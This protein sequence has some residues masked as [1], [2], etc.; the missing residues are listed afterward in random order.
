MNRI[1]IFISSLVIALSSCSSIADLDDRLTRLEARVKAIENILPTLNNNIEAL[2]NISNKNSIVSVESANG[3]YKLTLA[4][5]EVINLTQGS[6][7]AS[8]A[9]LVSIDKEGYWMVDYQDGNG[10][11]YILCD[12]KKVKAIGEDGL[13][14][15]FGVDNE[16]YW[17]VSYN[18]KDWETVKDVNG[19]PVSAIPSE[20]A[21]EY[22]EEVKVED[23]KLIVILKSGER[24]SIPIVPDFMFVINGTADLQEFNLG[25]LKSYVVVS[26]GVVSAGVI[27]K[28]K[29][30][31]VTL[32]EDQL[33][34]VAP[35][36]KTIVVSPEPESKATA[37]TNTDI[38]V[39]AVSKSGH[40][41]LSKVRVTLK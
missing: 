2:V 7:G 12:G 29:G 9:P 33:I 41:V 39:L 20:G 13:T 35:D 32:L 18:G 5:G 4:N 14:P 11:S 36:M 19:K 26:K 15:V 1:T 25:E 21:D 30:W 16:G 28:P 24:F 22:F 27:S 23:N 31:E 10:Y 38:C 8:N 40:A 17:T 37:D 6:V 34:V 3:R